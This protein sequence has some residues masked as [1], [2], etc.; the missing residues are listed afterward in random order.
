MFTSHLCIFFGEM[1]IQILCPF[2][3]EFLVFTALCCLYILNT[4]LTDIFF[5]LSNFSLLSNHFN[6][7]FH[8]LSFQVLVRAFW[9]TKLFILMNPIYLI[10]SIVCAFGVIS[11][12]LLPNLRSWRFTPAFSCLSCAIV[13]LIFRYLIHMKLNCVYKVQRGPS[14]FFTCMW[15]DIQLSHYSLKRPFFSSWISMTFLWK[16]NWL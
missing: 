5:P 3:M 14:S 10:L 9:S 15:M 4:D 6:L 12:K 8:G 2:L 16:I 13:T 11:K 1:I 7:P